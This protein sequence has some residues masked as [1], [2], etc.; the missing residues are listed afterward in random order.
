MTRSCRGRPSA[1]LLVIY[2]PI[3]PRM[4]HEERVQNPYLPGACSSLLGTDQSALAA[5]P[6]SQGRGEGP[7]E[8]KVTKATRQKQRLIRQFAALEHKVPALRRPIRILLRAGWML[9]RVPLAVLLI[10]GGLFSVFPL[11]GLWMLPLGLLLLA[12]DLPLVRPTATT[13]VIRGR[14]RFSTTTRSL[15]AWWRR[16]P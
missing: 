13:A 12:V 14:R 3:R 7:G 1:V 9:V 4:L 15:R 16:A 6:Q 10:L 5:A 11:L 8:A 2:L